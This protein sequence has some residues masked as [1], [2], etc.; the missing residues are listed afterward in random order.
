MSERTQTSVDWREEFW[1][2][3]NRIYLDC[4]AEGP[5][6]RAT[7]RAVQQA[8]ELKKYPERITSELHFELPKQTREALARLIGAQPSEI[9]LTS[10]ASDGVNAVARGLAWNS[11]DEIVLPVGEF[12]ANYFPWK[13]LER[14]GVRVRE[15]AAADGRFLTAEDLLGAL[16]EKTRL[17]A[18]SCVSYSSGNRVDVARLA[19]SC[20]ERGVLL[21]VD[22][23]QAVGALPLDVKQLGCHF[24]TCAGYKWLLSPYGTGFFYVREDMVEQLEVGD[25]NWLSVEGAANFNRLPREG[26]R[27]AAGATRWDSPETAN[28]LNLSA[29]KASVEFLL[30]VGV[31]SIERHAQRLCEQVV[32][33]YPRDRCVLR[34][35]REAARRG[36][37]VCLAARTPEI[38]R[39]L[40]DSLRERKIY[41]SL[42]Q[43]AL[44]I[45]PNIYNREWEIDRLLEALTV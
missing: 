2:F 3:E 12:P 39:Q 44:R 20:R 23:S 30:Q 6:P 27:L 34:S 22:G 43:D 19:A 11:G 25:I 28:F 36:T 26:W 32:A 9:A 10:G 21:F 8:L 37:F 4:A 41:V 16:T 38:T 15:V 24:L 7:L 31:E 18:V 40:W 14:R 5:F 45:A 1:D 17:V 42:R 13:H 33:N 35:P 29:V